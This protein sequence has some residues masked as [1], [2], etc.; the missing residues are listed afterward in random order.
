[1]ATPLQ[2]INFL[3]ADDVRILCE[4][5]KIE[6]QEQR[7]AASITRVQQSFDLWSQT[8][9][10]IIYKAANDGLA[11]VTFTFSTVDLGFVLAHNKPLQNIQ[12]LWAVISMVT[13]FL[14]SKKY[15]VTTTPSNFGMT[16]LVTVDWS[17]GLREK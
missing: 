13:N 12:D 14:Q 6:L 16:M 9:M 2:P 1:M 4:R 3:G 8:G 7:N 10:E 11:S 17:E 5:R 15:Y